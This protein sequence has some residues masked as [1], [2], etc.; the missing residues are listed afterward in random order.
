MGYM[1]KKETTQEK[2]NS[3]YYQQEDVLS[4]SKDIL[5]KY[6]YSKIDGYI[7]GGMIVETEAYAGINDKASHAYNNRFTP[8]TKTMYENGG[9]AY[10]YI[11][12]GIHSLLNIVT[13][14]KGIPHAILIRAIEPTTGIEIMLERRKKNKLEPL[15]T[16]GPASLCQALGITKKLDGT[17]LASSTL[18]LENNN[19]ILNE[20]KIIASPR[21]GVDYAKED[22]YLPYRFRIKNNIWTSRPK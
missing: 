21:V 15:L 16:A 12:Y 20:K 7:T 13:N 18:W 22:A 19:I 1:R 3:I 6:I 17:N 14:K 4:L 11:C 2:I 9:I 5:G 10:V 8:R